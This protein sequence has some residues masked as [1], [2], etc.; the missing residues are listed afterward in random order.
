MASKS[1]ALV[2]SA[3]MKMPKVSL[4]AP[5][6]ELTKKFKSNFVGTFQ[7]AAFTTEKTISYWLDE[8]METPSWSW[9]GTTLRQSGGSVGTPRNIVDT[10]KLKNSKKITTSFGSTQA[11]WTVR[12]GA[13]YANLVHY[14]G[15]IAPYGRTG[16]TAYIPGRPWIKLVFRDDANEGDTDAYNFLAEMKS[17]MMEGLKG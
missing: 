2:L 4:I 3:R 15:Y 7:K 16:D 8:A 10:G 14:G 1:D 5:D 13:P 11:K 6:K 9:S 12:Y 17:N